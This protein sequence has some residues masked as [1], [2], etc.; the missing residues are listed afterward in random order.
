MLPHTHLR[1]VR[2]QYKLEKPDGTS[3]VILDVPRYD[4]NWQTYYLFA[5]PLEIPAGGKITSTAW[6]DNSASNKSNPERDRR[7]EVGR[8]DVGGDAVHGLPVQRAESTPPLAA[9]VG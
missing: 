2:W 6:Y 7:R 1:G 8:P 3:E 4:F 9:T 5:T